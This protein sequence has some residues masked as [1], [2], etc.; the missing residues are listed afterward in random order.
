MRPREDIPVVR[1]AGIESGGVCLKWSCA[2]REQGGG[3]WRNYWSLPVAAAFGY[4]IAYLHIFSIGP[5]IEPLQQQFGWC[6]RVSLS[7]TIANVAVDLAVTLA[8]SSIGWGRAC[9]L[10]GTLL[11]A[12]AYALLGTATGE[13]TGGLRCGHCRVRD[14]WVQSTADSAVASR[15]EASRGFAFA[16]T[17]SGTSVGAAVFPVLVTS[18]IGS[19][20]WRT[21][22]VAT[23]GIWAALVFPVVFL[24]FRGAKE[25]DR[26]QRA[27]PAHRASTLT[28]LSLAEGLRVPAFY[29]LLMAGGLFAFTAMGI[30]VHFVP[31]GGQRRCALAAASHLAHRHLFDHRSARH[32]RASG[33]VP[34]PRRRGRSFWPWSQRPALVRWRQPGKPGARGTRRAHAWLGGR[35]HHISRPGISG[36]ELR[37]VVGGLLLPD[38]GRGIKRLRPARH[39][40]DMTRT[41]RSWC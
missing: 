37:R 33:P 31:S 12:A 27:A 2:S 6:A 25:Q 5:F 11:I 40:T 41:H 36:S 17:L 19:Y 10:T 28:G 21:A 29:K 16:I 7:I 32:R 18:L 15:F 9:W 14:L 30:V 24:F 4:S 20:G 22:F 13:I 1:Y 3:G 34:G 38:T 23:G 39:L 8:C 26:R 35:R